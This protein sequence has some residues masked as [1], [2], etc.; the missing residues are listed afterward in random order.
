MKAKSRTF[1]CRVCGKVLK[2]DD[3]GCGHSDVVVCCGD[4]MDKS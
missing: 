3:C 1:S 2:I 4:A